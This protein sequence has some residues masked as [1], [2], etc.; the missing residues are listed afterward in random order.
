[1]KG[2]DAIYEALRKRVHD[3]LVPRY[4]KSVQRGLRGFPPTQP[5]QPAVA[6]TAGDELSSG[7]SGQPAKW[8][9]YGSITVAVWDTSDQGEQKL[10]AILDEV[11]EA[12]NKK[13]DEII[14]GHESGFYQTTLGGLVQ[15]CGVTGQVEMYAGSSGEQAIAIIPVEILVTD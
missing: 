10:L 15:R 1:M 9:L 3:A 8:T 12:L 7:K 11:D 5:Y 14:P 2:R 6:I 4:A 13:G